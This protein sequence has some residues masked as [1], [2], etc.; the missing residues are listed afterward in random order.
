MIDAWAHCSAGIK[1]TIVGVLSAGV[2]AVSGGV[3][4]AYV[5]FEHGSIGQFMLATPVEEPFT[6][7]GSTQAAPGPGKTVPIR[8]ALTN[9]NS[10]P[11]VVKRL[12]VRVS[13]IAISNGGDPDGCDGRNFEVRQ[14]T[15][16]LG[17]VVEATGTRGLDELGFQAAE[18][19]QLT[20][21]NFVANQ[22]PCK[23]ALIT[24]ALTGTAA[25]V[26][27]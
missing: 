9:P 20:M 8:L 15:G 19:P 16:D 4:L 2:M 12:E 14:F 1:V 3:Y 17:F 25:K 11:I 24:L 18:W 10:F 13:T 6:I 27:A 5:A 26:A 23:R 22:D 7:S 21:L